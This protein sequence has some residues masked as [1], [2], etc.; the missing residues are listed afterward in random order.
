[1]VLTVEMAVF[2]KCD[3]FE[4]GKQIEIINEQNLHWSPSLLK[5]EHVNQVFF[6]MD[7]QFCCTT[8]VC[9]KPFIPQSLLW[10]SNK[11]LEGLQSPNNKLKTGRVEEGQENGPE[12][13]LNP[14][15]VNIRAKF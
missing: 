9:L 2:G 7:L 12:I 15:F 11:S 1:M 10:N 13:V 4:R 14:L 5:N 3:S 6:Y 8:T